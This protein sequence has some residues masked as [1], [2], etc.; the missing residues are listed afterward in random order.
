MGLQKLS[1]RLPE[2]WHVRREAFCAS[3]ILF[4]M[5]MLWLF[6]LFIKAAFDVADSEITLLT[7]YC[8]LVLLFE[9]LIIL[10]INRYIRSFF[11]FFGLINAYSLCLVFSARLFAYPFWF[12][13][14]II[15]GLAALYFVVADLN[16]RTPRLRPWLM[17][18]TFVA[19]G[20]AG[21][22]GVLP[23]LLIYASP[24]QQ[25]K[26]EDQYIKLVRFDRKPNVYLLGF[27]SL[28][29]ASLGKKLLKI[30]A[31]PYVDVI[32]R[33]GGTLIPNM[34]ADQVPTKYFWMNL[35]KIIP[36]QR[37]NPNDVVA[38]RVPSALL[39][40]FGFNNYTTHFVFWVAYFGE[41]NGK[42][43][44]SY[45]YPERYSTC[46]FVG[47]IPQRYGFLGYCALWKHGWLNKFYPKR[48]RASKTFYD[49][50]LNQLRQ[51]FKHRRGPYLYMQHFRYPGHTGLSYTRADFAEFRE[52][53]IERSRKAAH[54]MDEM[55]TL[56]K[57]N[58]PHA[59]IL[60]FG[61]HGSWI[62]RDVAF[63][64]NPQFF[65]QDRYGTLGAVFGADECRRYFQ[66]PGEDS[67]HTVAF[68]VLGIAKCLAEGKA[69]LKKPYDFG[70]IRQLPGNERFESYV[71][72]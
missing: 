13:T 59:I 34:F 30:D 48:R 61:D 28:V 9:S 12:Q 1:A 36:N 50:P 72:E 67:F 22:F 40:L 26:T 45:S 38:G 60:V 27:D 20:A 43:L 37:G 16:A 65:V 24:S 70:R 42:H 58:D 2:L 68:T 47:K 15:L 62:S 44:S 19:A 49:F 71:Y 63:S 23:P 14:L 69:M 66:P 7:S 3:V 33:H 52:S 10:S 29:P 32:R 64:D 51:R 21:I 17:A 53:Y 11:V 57:K 46:S 4:C 56:I 18:S 6:G 35:M 54:A 25:A 31:L 41:R 5:S 8:I 55:L 39:S